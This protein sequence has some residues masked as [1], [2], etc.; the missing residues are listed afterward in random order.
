M[1]PSPIE[2]FSPA[3]LVSFRYRGLQFYKCSMQLDELLKLNRKSIKY[4]Y[5]I[6]RESV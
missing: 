3:D 6:N 2:I 4:R 1:A 5:A